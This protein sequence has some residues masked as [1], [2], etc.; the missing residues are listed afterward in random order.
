MK[1]IEQVFSY[2]TKYLDH[3]TSEQ[4]NLLQ[5]FTIDLNQ[6]VKVVGNRLEIVGK[7]KN[8]QYKDTPI[9]FSYDMTSGAFAINTL[10]QHHTDSATFDINPSHPNK[11]LFTLP[12]F[13]NLD[14]SKDLASLDFSP[15]VQ[16]NM[17]L[18]IEKN[19]AISTIM[20]LF[21]LDRKPAHYSKT[22]TPGFYHLFQLLDQSLTS[23]E[24]C[25][26]FRETI[27]RLSTVI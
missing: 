1:S 8:G 23:L 3:T 15:V 5:D 4:K 21:D 20:N 27:Q 10:L 2:L 26:A 19:R 7:L 22:E 12:S 24:E 11:V 14:T 6:G 25:K 18:N 16:E 13:Q 9:S 17:E